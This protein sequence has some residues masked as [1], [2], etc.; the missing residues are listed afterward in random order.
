MGIQHS[1]FTIDAGHIDLGSLSPQGLYDASDCNLKLARKFIREGR[2]AP[3]YEGWTEKPDPSIACSKRSWL[4]STQV[5][6]CPICLLYY[7]AFINYTRCCNKPICTECLLQFK[8]SKDDPWR[9]ASCPYC[10][11]TNFGVIHVPPPFSPFYKSFYKRRPEL[12]QDIHGNRPE[13]KKRTKLGPN[14]PDVVLV[15][16]LRPDWQSMLGPRRISDSMSG[17]GTTRR[18]VVR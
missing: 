12:V 17:Y 3:F 16:Q 9:P 2:L 18:I 6:E 4:L 8:R 11:Q 1:K 7:P 15:D 10:T 14:D 5:T 13:T